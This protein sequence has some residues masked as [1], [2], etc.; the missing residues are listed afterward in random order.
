MK[1]QRYS[2]YTDH[3]T[4]PWEP[5]IYI[6]REIVEAS[7]R[8]YGQLEGL[9]IQQMRILREAFEAQG[10]SYSFARTKGTFQLRRF[11]IVIKE[12]LNYPSVEEMMRAYEEVKDF[13]EYAEPDPGAPDTL[14]WRV[15]EWD[16]AEKTLVSPQLR[17]SWKDAELIAPNWSTEDSIRGEAGIHA[18]RLPKNWRKARWIHSKLALTYTNPYPAVHGIVE[19]FGRF[20]LGEDGWR[21]EWVIIRG[22][23][24]PS[25]EIGLELEMVY[26]DIEVVYQDE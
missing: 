12:W 16:S 14:G 23:V 6:K 13:L 11:G 19:R 21:A 10:Y 8:S 3:R 15:W 5:E 1:R 4:R 7:T 20:V 17:T 9:R 18:L 2:P 25:T 24:A 26:P 22:L